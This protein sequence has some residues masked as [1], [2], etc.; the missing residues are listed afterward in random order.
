MRTGALTDAVRRLLASTRAASRRSERI[1]FVVLRGFPAREKNCFSVD[2][3]RANHSLMRS[4][5]ADTFSA[6]KKT[7]LCS[8]S[9]RIPKATY[10]E[11][12]GDTWPGELEMRR[13]RF[14][15]NWMNASD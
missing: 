7:V 3:V 9:W 10:C 14:E 8:G 1:T 2:R 13:P 6:G 12:G 11:A 5:S 15:H 4:R